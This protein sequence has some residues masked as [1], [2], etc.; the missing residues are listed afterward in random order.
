MLS[1]PAIFVAF[2]AVIDCTGGTHTSDARVE[3]FDGQDI[4]YPPADAPPPDAP[5]AIPTVDVLAFDAAPT[6]DATD[7][8]IRSDATSTSCAALADLYAHTVRDA[9]T[10]TVSGD[11]ATTVCETLCCN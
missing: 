1:R 5:D 7:D 8:S 4:D 9:E 10:C 2:F 3:I 6:T 11:C